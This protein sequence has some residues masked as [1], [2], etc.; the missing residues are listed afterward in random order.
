M[1]VA[2]IDFL[3]LIS[4]IQGVIK[5]GGEVDDPDDLYDGGGNVYEGN[6]DTGEFRMYQNEDIYTIKTATGNI[7]IPVPKF[8]KNLDQFISN[9][10]KMVVK[11][12]EF[13][14]KAIDAGIE[15]GTQMLDMAIPTF[16]ELSN[17]TL[18]IMSDLPDL[19]K[20]FTDITI[21]TIR[22]IRDMIKNPTLLAITSISVLI[23]LFL[24][25]LAGLTIAI[26][27]WKHI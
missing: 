15:F 9:L 26:K 8:I 3:Q 22:G 5:P 4:P 18:E 1:E 21:N 16:E 7:H 13:V 25:G 14:P 2:F 12:M 24:T 23:A 27:I 17:L 10:G 20:F 11:T 19:I 6:L